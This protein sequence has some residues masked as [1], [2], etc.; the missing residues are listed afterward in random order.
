MKPSEIYSLNPIK[1]TKEIW[2]LEKHISEDLVQH[3]N[4]DRSKNEQIEI[5]Y[6][7]DYCFD[8]RRVWEFFSVWFNNKPFMICEEAGREGDDHTREF[9]TNKEVFLEAVQYLNSL[10]DEENSLCVYN[11]DDEIE[12]MGTFYGYQLSDMYNENLNP[13]YK[14]GDIVN[15]VV[16][17]E[18]QFGCIFDDTPRVIKKVKITSVDQYNPFA[19]YRGFEVERHVIGDFDWKTKID[20]RE[21]VSIT[22]EEELT[23]NKICVTLNNQLEQVN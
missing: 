3:Y 22:S 5:R 15:A 8:G 14:V 16:V 21:I 2:C 4:I 23:G 7:A 17:I 12:N 10:S 11:E 1:K 19:T 20:T 13:V 6:Y 18:K 9:I